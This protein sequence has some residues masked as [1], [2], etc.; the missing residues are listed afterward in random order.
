MFSNVTN[1]YHFFIVFILQKK[2]INFFNMRAIINSIGY[3]APK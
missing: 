1:K 2:L 3:L